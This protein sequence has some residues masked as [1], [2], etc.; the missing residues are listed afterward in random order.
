VGWSLEYE[1]FF[2]LSVA[3]LLYRA[4]NVWSE[5]ILIFSVLAILGCNTTIS[6]FIGN[7][8]FFTNSLVLEFVF[9]VVVAAV[10]SDKPISV[11]A[12]FATVCAVL[13][14][15]AGDFS[16]RVIIAGI[17]AAVLVFAAAQFSRFRVMPSWFEKMLAALGDASYSIYLCQVFVISA[18]CKLVVK[19]FPSIT[20]DTLIPICTVIAVFA[21]YLVYIFAEKPALDLCRRIRLQRGGD[22]E[23]PAG[24][25][26]ISLQTLEK[27]SPAIEQGRTS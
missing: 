24:A 14:M 26:T 5:L 23:A 15:L 8:K 11:M 25:W 4:G 21:G 17:P 6:Q 27:A 7:Y 19:L 2:Y 10:I 13:L 1:M 12:I 20:L 22:P 18:V 3:L 16:S 9:G